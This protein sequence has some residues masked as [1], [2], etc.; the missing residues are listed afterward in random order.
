MVKIGHLSNLI[1]GIKKQK[2]SVLPNEKLK[3]P[4]FSP[5]LLDY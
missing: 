4:G 3:L 2:D 1:P 5:L